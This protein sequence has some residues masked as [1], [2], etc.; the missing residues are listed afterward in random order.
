MADGKSYRAVVEK[1][2]L[3]G[4][5]GPYAVARSE[6]LGSI[7]FSLDSKVWQ[8]ESWPERGTCVILSKIFEKRAGWRANHGRLV[9]PDDKPATSTSKRGKKP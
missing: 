7:T 4:N 6:E 5:H 3:D 1:I 8:E 9:L 2:I